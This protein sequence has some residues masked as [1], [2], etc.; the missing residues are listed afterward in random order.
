MRKNQA[1]SVDFSSRVYPIDTHRSRGIRQALELLASTVVF[2]SLCLSFPTLSPAQDAPQCF[3]SPGA[4]PVCFKR[5]TDGALLEQGATQPGNSAW[6]TAGGFMQGNPS[7]VNTAPGVFDCFYRGGDNALW[8]HGVVNNTWGPEQRLGGTLT[9]PPS[10]VSAS[11]GQL[12][13]YYRGADRAL[14]NSWLNNGRWSNEDNLGGILLDGPTCQALGSVERC[15]ATGTDNLRWVK[16]WADNRWLAW[17]RTEAMNS[18]KTYVLTSAATNKAIDVM[19]ASKDNGARMHQF[20]AHRL[21]NQ[22]WR[23]TKASGSDVHTF[24]LKNINSG[25]CLDVPGGVPTAGLQLIQ[26]DCHTG[27]NQQWEM[28]STGGNSFLMVSRQTRQCA[29]LASNSSSNGVAIVQKPCTG[30]STQL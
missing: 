4:S 24:N 16:T 20:D 28:R 7:C 12:S 26:W 21:T 10:C 13:C 14:K 8:R 30:A 29:S 27:P 5:G 17:A 15:E 3:S 6:V 25:K 9:S 19:A 22:Q 11:A 18:D 1:I 23:A 2:L